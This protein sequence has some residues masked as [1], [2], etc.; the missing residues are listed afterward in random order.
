MMLMSVI[1]QAVQAEDPMTQEGES[2]VGLVRVGM[3][4]GSVTNPAPVQIRHLQ[5]QSYL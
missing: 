4:P 5:K 3:N 2:S 1:I